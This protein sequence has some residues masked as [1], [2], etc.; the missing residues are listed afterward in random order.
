MALDTETQALLESLKGKCSASDQVALVIKQEIDALVIGETP[1]QEPILEVAHKMHKLKLTNTKMAKYKSGENFAIYCERFIDY[2][3]GKTSDN[4]YRSFLQNVDDETYS[5][6]K[7]VKLEDQQKCDAKIF[8]EIY[9]NRIYNNDGIILKN[10]LMQCQQNEG[11]TIDKFAFRLRQKADIAYVDGQTKQD[12][13]LLTFL[14]NVNSQYIKTRLNESTFANMDEAQKRAKHL[15]SIESSMEIK[16]DPGL[17]TI[18]KQ[19][20]F[21]E[22]T[23]SRSIRDENNESRGRYPERNAHWKNMPERNRSYSRSPGRNWQNNNY[24]RNKSSYGHNTRSQSRSPGRNNDRGYDYQR[25]NHQSRSPGRYQDR[26]Y[27]Y[28][29]NNNQSRSSGSYSDSYNNNRKKG[30]CFSCGMLGHYKYE[31]NSRNKNNEY[32]QHLN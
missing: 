2:V 32:R 6:L 7:Q 23:D 13:L 20:S 4:L 16:T 17:K 22:K 25:N 12:N 18:L 29:R 15:E 14:R 21:E 26:R 24:S 8:C 3:D 10:E 9:K 1:V 31:C 5:A 19:T 28:Q 27:D 30:S 11:E